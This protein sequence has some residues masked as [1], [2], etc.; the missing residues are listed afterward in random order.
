MQYAIVLRDLQKSAMENKGA[1]QAA[2]IAVFD[3]SGNLNNMGDIIGQ[4]EV[5]LGGMSAEQ[6]KA[7]LATLGFQERSQAALLTLVGT[8]DKIKE[9][10]VNLR[11]AGGTTKEV[12]DKQ[13]T[14][15]SARMDM[16]KNS[17]TNVGISLGEQLAPT[18]ITVMNGIAKIGKA[19]TKWAGENKGLFKGLVIGV[20]V[21]G[22]LLAIFGPIVM[23]VPL[24][25]AGFAAITASAAIMTAGIVIVVA[26]LAA[27]VIGITSVISANKKMKEATDR[28]NEVS[29]N[30]HEKLKGIADQAGLTAE[31]FEDLKKKYKGNINV[32]AL[33]IK[34]GEE[35]I[36]L[37]NAMNEV[38]KE[39]VEQQEE[40]KKG[41]EAL[42]PTIEDLIPPT[43]KLTTETKKYTDFLETLG[44]KTL[45]EKGDRTK[46][47]RGFIEDLTAAYNDG[48]ISLD[49]YKT[50]VD[51]AKR[52]ME[53]LST[54]LVETTIP[55]AMNLFDVLS[56]AP[57]QLDKE[58]IVGFP[59]K[60]AIA[61]KT[62][63]KKVETIWS[64]MTDGL[65]TKWAT[66][67]GDFIK[68][69]LS[70]KS[71]GE[72]FKTFTSN[73]LTQFADMVGQMIAKWTIGLIDKMVTGTQ[74][75]VETVVGTFK[76]VTDGALNLAKGFSPTGA[77]ASGIGAAVGTFLGGLIGPKGAGQRDTQLIKDNTWNT[78][79]NVINLHD[80]MVAQLHEIKVTGW[81]LWELFKNFPSI[82][83]VGQNLLRTQ[84]NVLKEMALTLMES[85]GSLH[86]IEDVLGTG[87]ST[88]AGGNGGGT[89]S[90]VGTTVNINKIQNSVNINGIM[91]TDR[92][93]TRDRLI[94]EFLHAL[95]Q[96]STKKRLQEIL[97]IA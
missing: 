24:I 29:G 27:L 39:R 3:A 14:S 55:E 69:G 21:L 91:I 73:I 94:P 16:A 26:A 67:W 36:E 75:A 15:L 47:L 59:G 93:Y 92:D 74:S 33:A 19:I 18:L 62:G 44:I 8:S 4:L 10:E 52:E 11:K 42:L 96:R 9:Y 20:G 82:I 77:I 38:G 51:A 54:E 58:G 68:G 65:Q 13:L 88:T 95:K 32:M 70:L 78:N 31:Q 7:E 45:K 60:I 89:T 80:A 56:Q 5:R 2:G 1:F 66:M 43:I 12:S 85:G 63:A 57:A 34:K 97:G 46:E 71:F 72:A 79:Q 76:D 35:G 87:P 17:I 90:P 53:E 37:Q 25:V 30:F 81:N 28:Y 50:A 23:M 86:R 40:E 22:G 64:K 83:E 84:T 48:K 61:A 6:K 49:D 41:N